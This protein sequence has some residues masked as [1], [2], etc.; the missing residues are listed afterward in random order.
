MFSDNNRITGIQLKRQIAVGLTGAFLLILTKEP[1]LLG[2]SGL[3]GLLTGFAAVL[4]YLLVL[5]RAAQAYRD[6]ELLLGRVGGT[7]LR[8]LYLSYLVFTGSFLLAEAVDMT[9]AYLL[10]GSQGLTAAVLLLAVSLLGTGSDL[11]RRGRMGEAAYP[12]LMLGFFLMLAVAAGAVNPKLLDEA[13]ALSVSGT[14][15]GAYAYYGSCM[16][17][18]VLPFLLN[19]VQGKGQAFPHMARAALLVTLITGRVILPGGFLDRFDILWMAFLLFSLL[20]GLGSVLFYGRTIGKFG[21]FTKGG[22][23]LA[24]LILAGALITWGEKDIRSFYGDALRWFYTPV[25]TAV[26][27]FMWLCRK[28][29]RK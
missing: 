1:A 6:P 15:Q 5:V 13:P 10:T 18:S 2:R 17:L 3:L 26:P 28:W 25:L 20:F 12:L 11:Q 9:T 24:L 22:Y 27:L 19:H 16:V 7:L 29:R 4:L 8:L 23:V 14:V 21:T